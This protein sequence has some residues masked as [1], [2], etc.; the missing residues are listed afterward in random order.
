MEKSE[1]FW[2]YYHRI[3]KM[4]S[5]NLALQYT[6][7]VLCYRIRQLKMKTNQDKTKQET[8]VICGLKIKGSQAAKAATSQPFFW[9]LCFYVL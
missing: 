7:D 8:L 4:C 5:Y 3:Y 9:Q 1:Q 2:I 6:E